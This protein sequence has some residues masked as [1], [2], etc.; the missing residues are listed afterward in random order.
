MG[1]AECQPG[2]SEQPE[3]PEQPRKQAE[4]REAERRTDSRSAK[5]CP[6]ESPTDI[7]YKD[8]HSKVSSHK[9]CKQA[10]RQCWQLGGRGVQCQRTNSSTSS[11]ASLAG[12]YQRT[13]FCW[14][15][16]TKAG[17]SW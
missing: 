12:S 11:K 4:F 14:K 9:V 5:S 7:V 15:T 10:R 2:E 3:K 13:F 1:A 8:Q 16:K 17:N 6:K